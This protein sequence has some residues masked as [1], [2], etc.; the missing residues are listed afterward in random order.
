MF[1]NHHGERSD[2]TDY[3]NLKNTTQPFRMLHLMSCFTPV[4]PDNEYLLIE[5]EDTFAFHTV[6]HNHSFNYMNCT[7]EIVEKYSQE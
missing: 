5:S 2:I 7:S 4:N 6:K 1:F 3:T